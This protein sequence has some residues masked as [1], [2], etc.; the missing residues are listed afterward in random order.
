MNI[1]HK[2]QNARGVRA[3]VIDTL[4]RELVGPSPGYPLVQ[5]NR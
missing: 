3:H 4:R 1:G 2:A 5:I